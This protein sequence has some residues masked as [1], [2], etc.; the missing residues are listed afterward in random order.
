VSEPD[1]EREEA[2]LKLGRDKRLAHRVL[3]AHRH[4]NETPPFHNEVIDLWHS[5][6]ERA[7]LIAFR[8]GAKSSLAEEAICIETAYRSF[9]N[10]VILGESETR[11]AER[12]RAIKH[13]LNTNV[14]MEDLFGPL[15]EGSATVWTDTRVVLSNGVCIQAYGRGQSLRG[16]K[17]LD[18]RPD[19]LFVDDLEDGESV[20]TP[21]ARKKW[22]DWFF[23][24]VLPAMAPSG[25]RRIR[26]AG[27]PLDPDALLENLA[28]DPRWATLRVPIRS[29]DPVTG[30][31]VASWPNRFPE[32]KVEELEADFR[33]HGKGTI[34]A[35]EYMC[36]AEDQ[37]SKAFTA[38]M[39]R[40]EP[41]VRTWHAVYAMIDPARTVRERSATTGAAVWSWIGNRLVVWDAYG[42]RSKPDEIIADIFRIDEEFHPVAIGVEEDGLNEFILQPL[43]QE[44][45]RRGYAI[46]ILALKAPKGKIDFIKGMQPFFKAREVIFAHDMPDLR[47]QLLSFPTGAIDVPNALAYALRMR[48]GQPMFDT[49]GAQHIAEGELIALQR[50]PLWLA[51]NASQTHTTGVLLQYSDRTLRVLADWVREGDPGAVLGDIVAA[52]GLEAGR[53]IRVL[54]GPAHF[55]PYDTLGMRSAAVRIP[56]ELRRGGDPVAGRQEIRAALVRF[57]HGQPALTIATRARWTLNAF[58]GGYARQVIKGGM[59]AEEAADNVYRTLVEALEAFAALIRGGVSEETGAPRHYA[60]TK[61]GRRYLTSMESR[62]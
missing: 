5:D 48:P 39:F 10:C 35:Q 6:V 9:K 58:A 2:I 12:L 32:E 30:A 31:W 8:G 47:D 22:S 27:T 28:K 55:G 41:T 19:L 46:P 15:G 13:E 61:D 54:A 44:Q 37:A 49:F 40:V 52:A 59:L 60:S 14:Y 57:Q 33:H 38:D 24:V 43:R 50:E 3:F 18:N 36:Q 34:F 51:V 17:H 23:A 62:R 53:P 4:P 29:K 45:I 42:N 26:V 11:A 1:A 25:E 56:T 20:A 21:E 7:L 16:V